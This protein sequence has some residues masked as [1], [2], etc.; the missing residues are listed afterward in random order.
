MRLLRISGNSIYRGIRK[1]VSV[2]VGCCEAL[3]KD[4]ITWD[5]ACLWKDGEVQCCDTLW[6]NNE[7]WENN[8]LWNSPE[9]GGGF[10]YIFPIE[11]E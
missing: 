6:N 8:C 10:P 1:A 11:L 5:D 2:V 9:N 4:N 3:W 7:L